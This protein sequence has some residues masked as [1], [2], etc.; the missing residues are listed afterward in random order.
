M[1]KKSFRN[2]QNGFLAFILKGVRSNH[3]F[4]PQC[5]KNYYYTES[6]K[7]LMLYSGVLDRS[8]RRCADAYNRVVF[9]ETAQES[10]RSQEQVEQESRRYSV[11]QQQTSATILEQAR[12]TQQVQPLVAL[13]PT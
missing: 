7:E 11:E 2:F 12:F 9:Q 5:A 10:R 4:A 6:Y 3:I 1:L 8:Y 13:E